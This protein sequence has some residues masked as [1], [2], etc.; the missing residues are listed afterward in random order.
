VWSSITREPVSPVL[1]IRG[2]DGEGMLVAVYSGPQ[3]EGYVRRTY[4]QI[5]Q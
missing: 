1:L 5:M 3:G 4:G 2:M